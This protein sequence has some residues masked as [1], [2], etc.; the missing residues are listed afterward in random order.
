[1]Q[2]LRDG[3]QSRLTADE[4]AAMERVAGSIGQRPLPED[5]RAAAEAARQAISH[6]S[7]GRP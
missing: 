4:A 5:D 7:S 6:C 2:E 3:W 1:M